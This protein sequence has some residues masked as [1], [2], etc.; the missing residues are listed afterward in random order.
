MSESKNEVLSL[1]EANEMLIQMGAGEAADAPSVDSLAERT[2]TP[3]EA[4]DENWAIQARDE[5]IRRDDERR[6]GGISCELIDGELPQQKKQMHAESKTR[7]NA[8]KW[9]DEP[10]EPDN[11]LIE[12][13]INVGSMFAI[14]GPA[15]AA[16][17]WLAEQLAVC[18]ASGRDFFGRNVKRQRVYVANVEVSEK[19]YGKRLRSICKRLSIS[20]SDLDGWLYVDNLRGE[21]ATWEWCFEDAKFLKAQTVI[22]DP[23][24][25]VFRG[26]ETDENDCRY[27]VD[28]MKKFLK[29]GFTLGVV[30]HAPKGKPGDREVVD[31][32]SGSS[33]LVRYP[34][35]VIA[36]MPHAKDKT[37]R[38]VDCS[39]LRDY[40][41]PDSFSV[42]FDEGALVLAEDIAPETKAS[43]SNRRGR[44]PE[45]REA[46]KVN[47]QNADRDNL[48]TAAKAYLDQCGDNLPSAGELRTHLEKSF[49][50]G[51]VE[52]FIKDSLDA[53]ESETFALRSAQDMVPDGEGGWKVKPSKAGG[54]KRVSTPERIEAFMRKF[55]RLPIS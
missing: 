1:E 36:I 39:V 34:E 33:V 3:P 31:M 12:N 4:E 27:A 52:K 5:A 29:A 46:E 37:A 35:N 21:N 40:P 2:E 16:K 30:F 54:K 55:D 15:K 22:I 53:P 47:K 11:P 18:L 51:K 19:Q 48:A 17:S 25:Q 10:E 44:T 23:F 42:K 41:A 49:A 28:E 9:I 45:E 24:Y 13:L 20:K 43:Y 8:A 14:V 26:K 50:K 7:K 32:I 38:V 6:A